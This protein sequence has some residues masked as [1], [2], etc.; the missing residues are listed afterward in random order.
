MIA[1]DTNILVYAHRRDSRFHDGAV[2]AVKALAEGRASWAIPWPCVHEFF[3][4]VTHPR[5]YAPPSTSMEAFAQIDAWLGS[6]SLVVIGEADNHWEA[7]RSLLEAG[8]IVGPMVHDARI[9]ALC[10]THGIRELWTVDRDFSRFPEL[11]TRNPLQ[12][13]HRL[14]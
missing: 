6:P 4:I 13:R 3:S 2:S 1:V 10:A 7:L 12:S 11:V 5:V 9:A 8:K 14:S